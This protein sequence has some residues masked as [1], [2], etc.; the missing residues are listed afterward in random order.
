MSVEEIMEELECIEDKDRPFLIECRTDALSSH[1][2]QWR[3]FDI[4]KI[5]D[6]DY[7]VVA[8]INGRK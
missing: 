3:E 8:V 5:V 4:E 7:A 1:R 6:R 2:Y